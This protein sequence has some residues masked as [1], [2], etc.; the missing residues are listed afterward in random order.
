MKYLVPVVGMLTA[1][2]GAILG[3]YLGIGIAELVV[4][5]EDHIRARR[6]RG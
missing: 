5:A 3:G 1:I 2:T 6:H 4:R